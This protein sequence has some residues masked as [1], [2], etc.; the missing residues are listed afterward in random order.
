MSRETK[1]VTVKLSGQKRCCTM[2]RAKLAPGQLWSCEGLPARLLDSKGRDP[3]APTASRPASTKSRPVSRARLEPIEVGPPSLELHRVGKFTRVVGANLLG[4]GRDIALRWYREEPARSKGRVLAFD[5]GT[6]WLRQA[7]Y[8]A[9][10]IVNTTLHELQHLDDHAMLY[11]LGSQPR[12]RRARD[13]A[14]KWTRAVYGAGLAT[15]WDPA[16][17]TLIAER[18][19]RDVWPELK[20]RAGDVSV[21]RT[22]ARVWELRRGAWMALS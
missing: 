14:A 4:L 13:F 16:R 12:E 19:P 2:K 20:L 7:D 15:D 22:C 1:R 9:E 6:V 5:A 17:V 11:A 10:E 3:Y 18:H 21:S 8:P